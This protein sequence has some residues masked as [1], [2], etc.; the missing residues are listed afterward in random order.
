M[1]S[2]L[3]ISG[4]IEESYLKLKVHS[5]G[6]SHTTQIFLPN[7]EVLSETLFP[8]AKLPFMYL[9]RSWQEK[10]YSPFSSPSAPVERVHVEVVAKEC[11]EH[12]GKV[13]RVMRVEY[14]SISGSGIPEHARTQ[15]I[16]WV[17]PESG[18]VLR[19]DVFLGNSKLRFERLPYEAAQTAGL[20]L[21]KDQF[22]TANTTDTEVT[23]SPTATQRVH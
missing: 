1:P 12:C 17:D 21:F 19:R 8:D 11:I 18:N 2:I 23:K 16:S 22:L 7:S 4:R 3:R 9:G 6:I 13:R 5:N 15:G 10:V 20:V 14:K